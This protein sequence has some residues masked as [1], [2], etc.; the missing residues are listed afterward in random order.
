MSS[1]KVVVENV[2][3]IFDSR[4]QDALA[5]LREG[6]D[7]DLVFART[8]KVV[9]LDHVSLSV[10]EGEMF[11]LMGLSGSGKS[12]LVRM[13]NGLLVPSAGK[14]FVD[15][16]D[17]ARLSSRQL[18]QLR[19]SGISMVFQSFALFPNRNV[20]DNAAFGLEIAGVGLAE[21]VRRASAA[22]E[23]VG[24]D[25]YLKKFPHEL[26]GGMRQRV[27]L[28]RALAVDPALLLMDEAFSALDPLNRKEMQEILLKLQRERRRTIV[29]VTHDLDEALR[30]G[31]RVAIMKNGKLV[32]LGT[33]HELI[34]HPKDDYVRA[35]FKH[36]DTAPYLLAS[37]LIDGGA[38]DGEACQAPD[39]TRPA[40]PANAR[41]HELIPQL[42]QGRGPLAVL[43]AY[44]AC[45]GLISAASA[46]RNLYRK[47]ADA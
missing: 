8:G 11:V 14:I 13:I 18:R 22:L 21:R 7:K 16:D 3:K 38:G 35:F 44:G 27:G 19:R 42:I 12:T 10:N 47:D 31:N 6:A 26:S 41:L 24:L 46:L 23:Q 9:G 37:D 28:A 2:S 39:P 36:A 20:L 30:I 17:V 43:D 45:I 40:V 34:R 15:G 29:F 5:L 33:P 32:Q 1:V 4:P 25:A